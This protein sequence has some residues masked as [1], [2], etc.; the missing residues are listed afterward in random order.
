MRTAPLQS[1]TVMAR[2]SAW[3]L[4][5]LACIALQ[6]PW[7]Q[8]VAECHKR[9]HPTLGSGD[10]HTSDCVGESHETGDAPLG[11]DEDGDH[12]HVA[13][14]VAAATFSTVVVATPDL[15]ASRTYT[16][17]SEECDADRRARV[18]LQ[19][20]TEPDPPALLSAVMLL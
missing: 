15:Y 5:F 11:D 18:T 7:V 1:R 19:R 14:A 12:T 20:A 17:S 9:V 4:V 8:C 3:S 13:I 6:V 2:L 10:C 16:P